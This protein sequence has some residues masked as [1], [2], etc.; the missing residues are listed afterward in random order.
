MAHGAL[1]GQHAVEVNALDP[2]KTPGVH[3][4]ESA[5]TKKQGGA[6]K[7]CTFGPLQNSRERFYPDYN[8]H[9]A[10]L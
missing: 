9:F 1:V 8:L 6:G 4:D 3:H 10:P 7:Q 2:L 5:I